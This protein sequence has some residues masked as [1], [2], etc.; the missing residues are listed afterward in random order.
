MYD[1]ADRRCASGATWR[2]LRNSARVIEAGRAWCPFSGS[3]AKRRDVSSMLRWMTRRPGGHSARK[4]FTHLHDVVALARP[5]VRNV[6]PISWPPGGPRD[7][8]RHVQWPRFSARGAA[9]KVGPQKPPP[10]C[11]FLPPCGGLL[12]LLE[13]RGGAEAGPRLEASPQQM[14][15]GRPAPNPLKQHCTPASGP[16]WFSC[17][18]ASGG[19]VKHGSRSWGACLQQILLHH[20]IT[21]TALGQTLLRSAA[22]RI[23]FD[24]TCQQGCHSLR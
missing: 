20:P 21:Q 17:Q 12:R 8:C 16:V 6:A 13:A 3:K 15:P 23:R 5:S 1:I 2:R 24:T 22:L 9:P 7:Y 14:E 11:F 4:R 18:S 10:G 19:F